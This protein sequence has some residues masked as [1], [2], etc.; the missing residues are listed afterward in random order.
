MALLKKKITVKAHKK[1]HSQ[2]RPVIKAKKPKKGPKPPVKAA[3]ITKKDSKKNKAMM[4]EL[5]DKLR[6]TET[7]N[8]LEIELKAK[9][10][11]YKRELECINRVLSHSF[12]RQAIVTLAGENS[13]EIIKNFDTNLS[14]EEI[15]KKLKLK[16]SDVRATLNKLHG[17]GLVSYYRDKNNETGWYSYTWTANGERIENWVKVCIE[18][19]KLS[20]GA[21][22]ADQYFCPECGINS[23]H[24]FEVAATNSFKCHLCSKNLEFLDQEKRNELVFGKK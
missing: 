17:E 23:I 4:K 1:L 12:A 8:R 9:K 6:E 3:K 21:E 16:I 15:S 10:E 2:K 22:N 5:R 11:A 14:D 13:L 18:T 19:H 20:A 24:D 7:K